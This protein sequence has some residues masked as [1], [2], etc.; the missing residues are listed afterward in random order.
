MAYY[1][2]PT[3]VTPMWNP[4]NGR[5]LTT[6]FKNHK[7]SSTYTSLFNENELESDCVYFGV[8]YDSG[9]KRKLYRRRIGGVTISNINNQAIKVCAVLTTDN[10][11]AKD[12]ILYASNDTLQNHYIYFA[13]HFLD[14]YNINTSSWS[15]EAKTTYTIKCYNSYQFNTV[16][17]N[18]NI[19]FMPVFGSEEDKDAYFAAPE[20]PNVYTKA[21]NYY[22]PNEYS[23][24]AG[25]YVNDFCGVY[26]KLCDYIDS[27]GS[28]NCASYDDFLNNILNPM[29]KLIDSRAK[30]DID[31]KRVDAET[32]VKET[33]NQVVHLRNMSLIERPSMNDKIVSF[34][35]Q[36]PFVPSFTYTPFNDEDKA[37][38]IAH[39]NQ[40][41]GDQQGNI[42]AYFLVVYGYDENNSRY[43]ISGYPYYPNQTDGYRLEIRERNLYSSGPKKVSYYLD[44]NNASII[45]IHGHGIGT[46]KTFYYY[47]NTKAC[48]DDWSYTFNE[49]GFSRPIFIKL[50]KFNK[51]VPFYCSEDIYIAT[52]LLTTGSAIEWENELWLKKDDDYQVPTVESVNAGMIHIKPIVMLYNRYSFAFLNGWDGAKLVMGDDYLIAPQIGAGRKEDDNSFTG[53]VMGTKFHQINNNNQMLTGIFGNYHGIQT[54]FINADDGSAI[55][56]MK[57]R[58]QII[59]DPSNNDAMLFS[60]NFWK[61][62]GYDGKPKS[63]SQ[64]NENHQ[65]ML[66]NLSAPEIRFGNGNFIIDSDGNT[67]IAGGGGLA[68]W[69][70][71]ATKIESNITEANGKMV[72]DSGATKSEELDEQ[73]RPIY[74]YSFGKIY[75]GQH[76]TLGSTAENGFYLSKEGLSIGN[77]IRVTTEN[78]GKIEVGKLSGNKKWT[79]NGDSNNSYI[80][81]DTDSFDS[82]NLTSVDFSIGSNS[83]INSIYIGT[84]G[85]RLGQHFAVDKEGNLAADHIVIRSKQGFLGTWMYNGDN[86]Y[87]KVKRSDK[88]WYD[89]TIGSDGNLYARK[90]ASGVKP[91][92]PGAISQ[93]ELTWEIRPDG[94]ASFAKF[95]IDD[96]GVIGGFTVGGSSGYYLTSGNISCGTIKVNGYQYQPGQITAITGATPDGQGGYTFNTTTWDVLLK[97]TI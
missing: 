14:T 49:V 30:I 44:N 3:Y 89:I 96:S 64:D 8:F 70:I 39:A 95:E 97:V 34:P 72:I 32:Q 54:L 87:G 22:D 33:L 76:T 94:T 4:E 68:G 5:D 81:Y 55:F 88:L 69:K 6:Y 86:L 16:E 71:N 35:T 50:N 61:E 23:Q 7:I 11:D 1:N 9:N 93:S 90:Y 20:D 18:I 26:N 83:H 13:N 43:S 45:N 37:I 92:D 51:N 53:I 24:P 84:D 56:G 42:T 47:P 78:G 15:G 29:S 91:E 79:I 75:A 52:H 12:L 65:G 28:A 40:L 73:G 41:F 82:F 85:I 59:I 19:P 31:S 67:S 48:G 74:T 38:I 25:E 80:S 46:E 2:L 63:Y 10:E 62:Y 57:K 36:G 60:G 17:F 58:S 27:I 21:L 77:S 66:I